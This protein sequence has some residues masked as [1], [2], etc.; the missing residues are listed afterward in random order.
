MSTAFT[1]IAKQS[2]ITEASNEAKMYLFLP[3]LIMVLI[4]V[5]DPER[6]NVYV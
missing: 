4:G 6:F 2:Q 1:G 3:T 5:A